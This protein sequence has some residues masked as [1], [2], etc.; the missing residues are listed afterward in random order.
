VI[1]PLALLRRL[2]S[3]KYLMVGG[4]CALLNLLIQNTAVLV[5]GAH[6]VVASLLSFAVLTPL[7]FFIH[8][9]VTFQTRGRLPAKRFVLYTL[10][11]TVLLGVNLVLMALF[12]DLLHVNVSVAIVLVALLLHALGYLYSRRFVFREAPEALPK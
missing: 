10:Q 3:L 6:Y 5:F 7:S 1:S 4:F 2:P 8:K 12:V 11:W 9:S